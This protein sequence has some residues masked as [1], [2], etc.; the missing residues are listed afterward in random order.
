MSTAA[1][2]PFAVGVAAA[3]EVASAHA[4]DVD[5]NSRFPHEAVDQLRQHGALG[6]YVDPEFGGGGV[7]FAELCDACFDLGRA[8]S[9]TGMVFAMH[10][11]QVASITRHLD[12]APHMG[13]YLRRLTS[14]QRLIASA[15]SE[16]G[17][18]GDL[19]TSIAHLVDN[20]DG[21]V[22]F[23]KKAPTVSYGAH[24]EDL[25][26]TVRRH[27]NADA[28]DQVMVLTMGDESGLE[29]T[30]PWDTIGMRGTC[31]PAF[32]VKAHCPADRVIHGQ[33]GPICSETM[34]PFSHIL[35]AYVWL[36][37]ARAAVGRAQD[38]VRAQSRQR[39]GETPDTAGRLSKL[40]A[41]YQGM[42]ATVDA[43]RDEYI[44]I[45]DEP[46]RETLST[47]GYGLRVNNLKIQASESV[48]AICGGALQVLGMA[49]YR[50]GTPFS[51]GRMIRD[52]LSAAL[53][54]GNE[55]IHQT[56][57]QLL[58]MQREI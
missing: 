41:Q 47:F 32:E 45:M 30:A 25:L 50:N 22:S 19:R 52:S 9:A 44:A 53:M 28:S 4:D 2:T 12:A 29:Q 34:V 6:A 31:S 1:K 46:G 24:A 11:I 10:Q 13:D 14:E 43:A 21:T 3:A 16:V 7:S 51:V 27:E 26:T 17:T 35:W 37:M 56:N 49:G 55:R 39:P 54:I 33:F 36:G 20:G 57:A 15:T 18:G 42:R 38:M 23:H 48:A 8:C 5:V 40:V 58:L